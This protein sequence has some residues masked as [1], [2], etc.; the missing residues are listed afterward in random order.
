MSIIAKYAPRKV[1]TGFALVMESDLDLRGVI[2][3]ALVLDGHRVECVSDCAAVLAWRSSGEPLP[4]EFVLALG[5]GEQDPDWDTLRGALD[6]DAVL[7]RAAII[8]LLTI[9]NGMTFPARARFV[10]KPFAIEELLALVAADMATALP[11]AA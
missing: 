9:R 8:V 11:P 2:H 3:D 4:D 6:D 10:Q 1:T 5:A 7:S